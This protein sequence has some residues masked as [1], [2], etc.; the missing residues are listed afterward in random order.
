MPVPQRSASVFAVDTDVEDPPTIVQLPSPDDIEATKRDD[1]LPPSSGEIEARTPARDNQ[2]QI[3]EPLPSPLV[4][5]AVSRPRRGAT[6]A[7]VVGRRGA[8]GPLSKVR[9]KWRAIAAVG[10][11]VV[12]VAILAFGGASRGGQA[13]TKPA[14]VDPPVTKAVAP[15]A[16]DPAPAPTPEPPRPERTWA[17]TEIAPSDPA[18]SDPAPSAPEPSAPEPSDPAAAVSATTQ[19]APTAAAPTPS[20]PGEPVPSDPAPAEP[21]RKVA[22][23]APPP[24]PEIE[25]EP[26]KPAPSKPAPSKPAPA[27]LASSKPAPS[28]PAPRKPAQ[29]ARPAAVKSTPVKVATKPAKTAPKPASRPAKSTPASTAPGWN[30]NALFPKHK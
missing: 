21:T 2:T 22:Q 1:L 17:N 29:L 18:P 25:V 9:R 24:E 13:E 8:T 14:L 11:A 30:P 23:P 4:T 6:A 12:I 16:P 10:G 15:P 28:K 3:V 19:P 7:E 26:A 20:V 27:K 5:D